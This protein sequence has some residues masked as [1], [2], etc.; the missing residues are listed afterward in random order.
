VAKKAPGKY[1]GVLHKLTK[2]GSTEPAQYQERVE[3]VKTKLRDQ[4]N[5]TTHEQPAVALAKH[6]RTLRQRQA[7]LNAQAS[8]L[9]ME[10]EAAT[11][12]LIDTQEREFAGWGEYGAS[13]NMMRLVT[14]DTLRVSSEPYTTFEDRD[15]LREHYMKN[16]LER[17]LAPAWASVNA[18]NKERLLNGEPELPGTKIYVKTSIVFTQMKQDVVDESVTRA[19]SEGTDL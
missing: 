10:L 13:P 7:E 4:F 15:V 3:Q 17:L 16:G 11:Q 9:N 19:A 8:I 2:L 6:Y 5:E 1:D 18:L 12:L 14:G